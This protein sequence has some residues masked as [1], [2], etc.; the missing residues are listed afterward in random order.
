[1]LTS[2]IKRDI[3][4]FLKSHK[5]AKIFAAGYSAGGGDLQN[6]LQSLKTLGIDVELGGFLD[7]VESWG[8]N[9]FIPKNVKRAMAFYEKGTDRTLTDT[10]GINVTVQYEYKAEDSTFT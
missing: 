8:G 3:E 5:G 4:T 6:L 2:V 10:F 9:Q 1:M 7:G